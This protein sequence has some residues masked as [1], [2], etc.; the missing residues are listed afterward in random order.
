MCKINFQKPI[1]RVP[2]FKEYSIG[3][4]QLR[5][6]LEPLGMRRR[7][8]WDKR[9]YYVSHED[10]GKIFSDVL[11]NLPKYTT[12]KF[13]CDNFAFLVAARVAEKYK[14]NTCGIVTGESP[15]GGGHCWNIFLSDADL[16]YLEPQNGNV[17]SIAENSR[18]KAE[19]I[20]FG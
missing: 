10:W 15:S 11:L 1:V 8:L 18:Y 16:F 7:Y 9:Y 2:R 3:K 17:F 13:D 19:F 5:T 20:F 6:L 14:L 4:E 12:D